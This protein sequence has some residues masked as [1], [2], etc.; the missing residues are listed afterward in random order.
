MDK[1]RKV[2]VDFRPNRSKPPRSRGWTRGYHAHGFAEDDSSVQDERV[3]AKGDL[4]RK[5][6]IIADDTPAE[7]PAID[8]SCRPGRVL[9][10]QGLWSMVA[11]D[12]GGLY[13]CAIRR[14]LRTLAIDEHG[15]VATGDRVWFRPAG[16]DEGVIEH[17][18][19]RRGVLTRSSYGKEQVL[20]ANV[21]QVV[22][23]GSLAEPGLKPH[24]VDRYVVNAEKDR[25]TP[26]ICLNKADLVDLSAFQSFI[27]LYSQLGWPV[28]V[29]SVHSGQG[30]AAL[31]AL[32]PGR[33]TVFAG[34]SGVG[35][36]SLLNAIEPEL[37]RKVAAVSD[38]TEKGKHTT[39]TAELIP[40]SAG[41]WGVDTPGIRQFALADIISVELEGYFPEFRP[42]VP[43]CR[44][45]CC[46]HRHEEDCAVKEAVR[47][48]R[49]SGQRY[50]SYWGLFA[51]ET[52]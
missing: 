27:G 17:V 45:P 40:L 5:R 3:R 44:F 9:R 21:D 6:T 1:K 16:N 2:R 49:I 30:I 35:K 37:A 51:G 12:D 47:R 42:Y 20:V 7:L 22:I 14:V 18:A 34:Q 8:A 10:V 50:E 26:V 13:R 23:V 52:E 25:I 4:S 31:K 38:V 48:R 32:L 36:S 39:T 15:A 19:P 29:T 46:T 24:L 43:L 33:T 11:A 41:G 28:V